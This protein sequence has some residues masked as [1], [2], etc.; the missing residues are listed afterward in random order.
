VL[1]G[2]RDGSVERVVLDSDIWQSALRSATRYCLGESSRVRILRESS[3]VA[4]ERAERCRRNAEA[5]YRL[6]SLGC[7]AVASVIDSGPENYTEE[8]IRKQ[9]MGGVDAAAHSTQRTNTVTKSGSDQRDSLFRVPLDCK[10]GSIVTFEG[11]TS[12]WCSEYAKT[13][14][15]IGHIFVDGRLSFVPTT[16][17]P[18]KIDVGMCFCDPS[19]GRI[20]QEG[21]SFLAA[22]EL[23][24]GDATQDFGDRAISGD[25]GATD[26]SQ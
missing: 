24:R 26:H 12:A 11:Q 18:S 1:I 5:Y 6:S 14:G 15:A 23:L 4:T 9:R 21:I 17:K 16:P 7:H 2:T 3:E 10:A 19:G 20:S 25:A 8:L 13:D 22:I